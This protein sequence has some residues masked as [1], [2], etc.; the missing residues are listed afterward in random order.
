MA[1]R[2]GATRARFQIA[3]KRGGFV[4]RGKGDGGFE[5]PRREFGGVADLAAVVF[6]E[7]CLQVGSQPSVMAV[8]VVYAAQDVNVGEGHAR[9]RSRGY[10]KQAL[11][12]SRLAK[13]RRRASRYG[14]AASAR[15]I[16]SPA[17]DTSWQV[18]G[19]PS[20]SPQGGGWWRCR[21]LNLTAKDYEA[22]AVQWSEWL[23]KRCVVAD[24][25]QIDA[26]RLALEVL[27][28]S[29][30]ALTGAPRSPTQKGRGVRRSSKP[31]GMTHSDGVRKGGRK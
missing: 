23:L 2:E 8:G 31:D 20:R 9:R 19:L 29:L 12:L 17:G 4:R 28:R 30:G 26:A 11:G 7:P 13:A 14:V 1:T 24:D 18:S 3:F 21:D 16:K 25:A 5:C 27:A 6:G 15:K 22:F 10:A